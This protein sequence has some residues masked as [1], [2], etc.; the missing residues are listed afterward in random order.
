LKQ[1]CSDGALFGILPWH[2]LLASTEEIACD[3]IMKMTE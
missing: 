1:W 2:V 3:S